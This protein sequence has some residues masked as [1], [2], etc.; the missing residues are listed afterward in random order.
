[1]PFESLSSLVAAFFA[2]C[3]SSGNN[4]VYK[5]S[6]HVFKLQPALLSMTK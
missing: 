2:V 6:Y 4:A 1:M 3:N 5:G